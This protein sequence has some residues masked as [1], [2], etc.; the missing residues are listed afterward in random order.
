MY[1]QENKSKENKSR[2]VA[3]NVD[4]KNDT[5][6][7]GF[8]FV[9]NRSVAVAQKKK[10]KIENNSIYTPQFQKAFDANITQFQQPIFQFDRSKNPNRQDE[11]T[12]KTDPLL[13]SSDLT[14]HHV[15][16]HELLVKVQKKL[17][18]ASSAMKEQLPEWDAVTVR[19]M[20]NL[21][22]GWKIDWID[23]YNILHAD[24]T[25]ALDSLAKDALS[26]VKEFLKASDDQSE[27]RMGDRLDAAKEMFRDGSDPDETWGSAFYEWIP[28]NIVLGPSARKYDQQD[29]MALDKELLHL[30]TR[31]GQ[32]AHRTACEALDTAARA[33]N[34]SGKPVSGALITAFDAA[35]RDVAQFA[36][37]PYGGNEAQWTDALGGG[38]KMVVDYPGN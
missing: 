7:Y 17:G 20:T 31:L 34:S 8:G 28:G 11:D 3:N 26:K 29:G 23:R 5:G 1:A 22:S 30:F 35:L 24:E 38:G 18:A 33:I 37:T 10:Q 2:A 16:P 6:K 25:I 13:D 12:Y 4:Q 14:E 19:Q 32:D 9:D 15:V 21:K 36:Y 27:K